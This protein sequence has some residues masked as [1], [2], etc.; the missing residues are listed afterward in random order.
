MVPFQQVCDAALAGLA[1]HAD[2]R[3]VAATYVARIDRKVGD[4]PDVTVGLSNP[5]IN[6]VLRTGVPDP[7]LP[8]LSPITGLPRFV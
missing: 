1:G 5:A 6:R 3:F 2:H 7:T 8:V 4:F